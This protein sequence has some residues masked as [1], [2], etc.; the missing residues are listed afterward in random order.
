MRSPIPLTITLTLAVALLGAASATAQDAA[1]NT[2]TQQESKQGWRLLFNGR[3]L[4]GWEARLTAPNP[5]GGQPDWSV[6]DG[7]LVCGGGPPSW[8]GTADSF[9]DYVL[10]LQFR[11]REGVNSGVFLR[12]QKEGAP[13]RT[14]YELQIWDAQPAG[15]N[16]GS[17]V[18]AVKA[19]PTE[20]HSGPVEP[21]R[22][23]AGRRS[24]HGDPQRGQDS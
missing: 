3:S 23:H 20:I 1:P 7:A 10:E 24:H 14:G 21:V 12:S 19:Q 18:G 6:A 9:S 13:H 2:L 11:G 5:Q 16:T 17:L 4:D 8:I 15:Y 22:D